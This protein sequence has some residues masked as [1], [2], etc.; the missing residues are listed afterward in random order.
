MLDALEES[1]R[2]KRNQAKQKRLEKYFEQTGHPAFYGEITKKT[3]KIL[4]S[5]R[6]QFTT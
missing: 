6:L 4:H 1:P 5:L 3:E 2:S